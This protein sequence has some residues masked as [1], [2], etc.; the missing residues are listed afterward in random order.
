VSAVLALALLALLG[1]TLLLPAP[2]GG[3][4]QPGR[5]EFER[6][7]RLVEDNCAD[8]VSGTRQALEDG[9]AAL[10]RALDAGFPDPATVYRLLAEAYPTLAY[11]HAKRDPDAQ[12]R[13]VA[14][15]REALER[16]AALAP[17]DPWPRYEPAVIEPGR[18]AQLAAL[19]RLLATHPRHAAAH[20]SVSTILAERGRLDEA[21]LALEQAVAAAGPGEIESYRQRLGDL[22]RQG[23][24]RCTT[25]SGHVVRGQTF[26]QRIGDGLVFRLTPDPQGWT[27]GVIRAGRPEEDYAGIATPP[28]RGINPR[29]VEGWHF[30]NRANTG[31]NEGDVNAPQHERGFAFVVTPEGYRAA[32]TALDTLLWGLPSEVERARAREALQAASRGRGALRITGS[33]LG[34]LV[35]GAQARFES[36]TFDLEFCRPP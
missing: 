22:R 17:D 8:C 1:A 16:L 6:G 10:R 14:L 32:A 18:D 36:L 33:T 23:G 4:D 35:P 26:E 9:V 30:R 11:L 24:H 19:R 2:A 21:I 34:N 29:Y 28:Y 12:R 13:F 3:A 20:F 31:P 27:I 7:R 15:H 25:A 5:V